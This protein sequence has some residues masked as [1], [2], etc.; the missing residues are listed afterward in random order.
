MKDYYND[1]TVNSVNLI[2]G[3]KV[4]GEGG[5]WRG[6]DEGGGEGGMKGGG[7]E[8]IERGVEREG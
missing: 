7:E 2:N 5:G 1:I 6:R 8:G 4:S 3:L